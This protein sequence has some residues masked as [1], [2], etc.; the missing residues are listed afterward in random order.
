MSDTMP[1]RPGVDEPPVKR[2]RGSP[3]RD[4]SDNRPLRAPALT[5][6]YESRDEPRQ[7]AWSG[8][9]P[10]LP[11]HDDRGRYD[12]PI[13]RLPG[14]ANRRTSFED[15]APHEASD[16]HNPRPG[17][18]M[19]PEL[20]SI[21][22]R[23]GVKVQQH[24]PWLNIDST[25][26]REDRRDDDAVMERTVLPQSAPPNQLRF[27]RESRYSPEVR[28]PD[29][30]HMN[31][32]GEYESGSHGQSQ[33]PSRLFVP[34]TSTIPSPAY[35]T[36]RVGS[37]ASEADAREPPR[38]DDHPPRMLHNKAQFLGLFSD[39]F[40]SLQDSRKLKATLEYQIRSSNALLQTL[41]RSS[42]VFEETVERRV[43]QETAVWE[44]RMSKLENRLEEMENRL[45]DVRRP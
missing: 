44:S 22:Q 18:G 17:F 38:P 25:L 19:P 34:Q 41:Q 5:L 6:N 45:R 29:I 36:V 31:T 8:T 10:S 27:A 26:A 33:T 21:V 35:H 32:R 13:P 3:L 11:R 14:L 30:S 16:I 20:P 7:R 1:P 2:P 37:G 40:D 12:A 24:R 28:R 39:F 43:R 4:R 9:S 42:K 23:R 15:R